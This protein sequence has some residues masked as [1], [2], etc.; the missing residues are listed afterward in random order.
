MKFQGL[1]REEVRERVQAGQVNK[2]VKAPSKSVARIIID[3]TFTYFNGV[4]AAIATILILAELY[5][6]LTFLGVIIANTL[7]G[8][9]QELRAKDVLDRLNMLN[10]QKI[11]VVRDG[12]TT[13]ISVNDLV[14]DDTV[15]LKAGDQ[16]PADAKVLEGDIVVNEA[17]L[18]GEADEIQKSR[19][20]ELLSGSFVISGECYAILMRVGAES[21]ISKLTL[22]AKTIKSG[23]QSEIIRSL[24]RIVKVAGIAIIPVG[25]IVYGHQL[26]VEHLPLETSIQ[27]AASAVLGMIPEGLFLLASVSLAVSVMR[28]AR[29]KV[30]VHE[31]K[32]IETLARVDVLC[33]D[34]T[35]TITSPDM[36][37]KEWIKLDKKE[38]PEKILTSFVASH[39]AD[40][41]T[42]KALKKF[43]KPSKRI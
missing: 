37:V 17:L 10:V 9:L 33:V 35:G 36:K 15:I 14:L 19:G 20:A 13:P 2:P 4:F 16:I 39:K 29:E 18:T 7:I 12:K 30:L 32:C 43:F 5:R 24:N 3:N 31:M 34:K 40:N 41:A 23:E 21:Y 8:I 26:L 28:L 22:Q 27:G 11:D 42:M 38:D 6:D 25:V 1:S